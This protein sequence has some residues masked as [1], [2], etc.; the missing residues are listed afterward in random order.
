[1]QDY[2]SAID[3]LAKE[4]FVDNDRLGCVGASYGGYSAFFLAGVH[5]GRFKSFIAHD[6]VFNLRSMYGTTEELFFVNWDLGGPYW[7][8]DNAAAQK[9]YSE[10]NP[11]N[12]VQNWDTPILIF[13]GGKDFRVPQGQAFE[14]F[15]AARNQGIKSR[16]VYFPEENH[17][18][19][20]PQNGLVWQREFFKW[21][22][23]TL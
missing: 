1:M 4:P 20:S 5:E 21:L 17:W 6:G 9:S 11:V 13:Q 8:Q 22:K 15:T 18:V 12:F 19:L 10:F 2:L 23:E 7:E 16:L 3:S 14:A